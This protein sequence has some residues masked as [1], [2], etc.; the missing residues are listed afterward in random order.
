MGTTSTRP[1]TIEEF[2]KL[3]LPRDR[4][5]ELRNGE[6]VEVSFPSWVH[7]LL[8]RRV[9]RLL[10]QAFPDVEVLEEMPLQVEATNDKRSADVGVTT[11]NRSQTAIAA[12]ALIGAPELVAEV[13]SPSNSATELK[14]YRRL[15]FANGTKVFLLVDPE[16]NTVEV[17]LESGKADSVLRPGDTLRL[18]LFGI[19]AAIPVASIFA[20]ITLPES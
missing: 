2:D 6:V 17:Y 9:A 15:C 4:N 8:Q 16:D 3:D 10:N 19:Q 1:I 18:S 7:K 12:R 20:G 14:Q 5:W 13:V 11:R